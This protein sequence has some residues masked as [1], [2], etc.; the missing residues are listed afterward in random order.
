M[1]KSKIGFT[2]IEVALFLALSGLLFVGIAIGVQNSVYQQRKN[3]SVQ[4]FIEFL[5]SAYSEV[6]N[7]Q[8][9][10]VQGRSDRA[11]YGRLITFGEKNDFVG[12]EVSE[13]DKA[14]SYTVIGDIR[15]T[16]SGNALGLLSEL[17]PNT[18]IEGNFVGYTGEYTPKW[19]ATIVEPC[20]NT[21]DYSPL[22]SALLIFRHPNSGAV[23]TYY[24]NGP[25]EVN[26]NKGLNSDYNPLENL[27]SLGFEIRQIDFCINP[28][29]EK[30]STDMVDIRIPAGA[31][32]AS[33]IE[34][35]PSDSETS[36]CRNL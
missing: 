28:S 6:E 21:C 31:R 8:N 18:F 26:N 4:S 15:K 17:N 22:Q 24:R 16:G 10:S 20:N 25:L 5:R 19:D 35:I 30:G 1:K 11:I 9:W 12:Q 33:A 23:Y 13:K 34:Q 14:F 29:G 36:K 2:L 7:V 32:N 27:S 3:D